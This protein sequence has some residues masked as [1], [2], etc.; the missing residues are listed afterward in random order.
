MGGSVAGCGCANAVAGVFL[1][2]QRH[3]VLCFWMCTQSLQYGARHFSIRTSG[4]T[5]RQVLDAD[6]VECKPKSTLPDPL[7]ESAVVFRRA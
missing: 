2:G 5:H 7:K 1:Q 3:A 4:S 6:V